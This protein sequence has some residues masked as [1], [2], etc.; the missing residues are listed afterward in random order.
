[1]EELSA[2]S[3][4]LLRKVST[5]CE[6]EAELVLL[7]DRLALVTVYKITWGEV[8]RFFES[9]RGEDAAFNMYC[10]EEAA[11]ELNQ[12][13]LHMKNV[14]AAAQQLLNVPSWAAM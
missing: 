3:S 11:R 10:A 14:A 9:T 8:K 6:S 2:T 5:S 7:L 12:G 1:M 4:S 13:N